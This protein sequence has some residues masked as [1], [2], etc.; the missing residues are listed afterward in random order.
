VLWDPPRNTAAAVGQSVTI[1]CKTVNGPVTW[2]YK[3]V[4]TTGQP[5]TVFMDGTV[6]TAYASR[7]ITVSNYDLNFAAVQL[8]DAG[9]YSC[10][11]AALD[12]KSAWLTVFG[13]CP[14]SQTS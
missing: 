13:K 5:T 3:N 1:A 2:R 11:D 4:Q 7:N 12:A 6:Q 9:S 10:H 8:S 14:A